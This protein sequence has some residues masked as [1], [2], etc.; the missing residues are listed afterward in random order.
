MGRLLT[1]IVLVLAFPFP[2]WSFEIVPLNV[3]KICS[4]L[5]VWKDEY[6]AYLKGLFFNPKLPKTYFSVGGFGTQDENQKM[7]I[8]VVRVNPNMPRKGE[9]LLVQ[10]KNWERI[11]A[12]YS[13]DPGSFWRAVPPNNDFKCIGSVAKTGYKKPVLPRYRCIHQKFLKKISIS[14]LL[15]SDEGSDTEEKVTIFKLKNSG[16]FVAVKGLVEDY[17]W[18][19]IK[20]TLPLFAVKRKKINF[21][22]KIK[23]EKR[24][25]NSS[26]NFISKDKLQEDTVI[27]SAKAESKNSLNDYPL[28]NTLSDLIFQINAKRRK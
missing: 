6:S 18:Y 3:K 22:K 16:S 21:K 10:P 11:W 19:D 9:T 14:S 7:C 8:S 27:L 13:G 2:A 1:L 4:V 23:K 25:K 20:E 24:I 12:S 26:A 15:W 28:V 5:P 17:D